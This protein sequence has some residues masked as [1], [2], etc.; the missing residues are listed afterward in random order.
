[1]YTEHLN[2]LSN[3][4]F[5]NGMAELIKVAAIVGGPL[6]KDLEGVSIN[7]LRNDP[8]FL[9]KLIK[10][11]FATKLHFL[12]SDPY[13]VASLDRELNFGHCLGHAVEAASGF[14]LRHGFA[15]A[16]GM[17]MA[18]RIG[19]TQGISDKM[20]LSAMEARLKD[21]GLPTTLPEALIEDS[22]QRVADLRKVRNGALRMALPAT[23]GNV[24]F[25]NDVTFPEFKGAAGYV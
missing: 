7:S 23:P 12:A 18:L 11:G 17:V 20:L 1:M 14:K 25:V 19:Y 6:W 22:W 3:K 21:H 15:V 4:E 9:T 13:E 8:A 24:V 10:A 2:S 5:S 16:I